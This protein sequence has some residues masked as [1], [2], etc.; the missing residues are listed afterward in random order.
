VVADVADWLTAGQRKIV[1]L[2]VC[3]VTLMPRTGEDGSDIRKPP[4]S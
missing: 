2:F 1:R 4:P 3:P